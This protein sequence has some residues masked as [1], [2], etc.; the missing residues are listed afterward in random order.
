[1]HAFKAAA[2][3]T[4][5]TV[6]GEG[7]ACSSLRPVEADPSTGPRLPHEGS[8]VRLIGPLISPMGRDT[9]KPRAGPGTRVIKRVRGR[10][11]L[12]KLGFRLN[13]LLASSFQGFRFARV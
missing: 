3:V 12:A 9:Q 10:L 7:G 1:M 2:Y 6:A 4:H 8:I 11:E 13:G 5:H